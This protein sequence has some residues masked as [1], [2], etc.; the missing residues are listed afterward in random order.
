MDIK[1]CMSDFEEG[2]IQASKKAFPDVKYRKGCYFHWLQA[3]SSKMQGIGMTKEYT[4]KNVKKL[5]LLTVIPKDDIA[6]KGIP[7]L[8]KTLEFGLKKREKEMWDE[9]WVYFKNYWMKVHLIS[10]WNYHDDSD[11]KNEM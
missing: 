10:M 4:F 11:W 7:Y 5:G 6:V 2:I 1:A 9:F 8:R 3:L